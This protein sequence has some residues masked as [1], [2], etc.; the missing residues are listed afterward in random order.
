[1]WQKKKKKNE[2]FLLQDKWGQSYQ[3]IGKFSE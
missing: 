1:M 2:K 3:E